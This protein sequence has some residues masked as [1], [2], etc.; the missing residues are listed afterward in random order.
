MGTLK[1][2]PERSARDLKRSAHGLTLVEV[3]LSIAVIAI[4]IGL[5]LPSI[6]RMRLAA[7]ELRCVNNVR[8]VGQFVMQYTA[9]AKDMFPSWYSDR[10]LSPRQWVAYT[11]QVYRGL[12]HRNWL[13]HVGLPANAA[14]WHCPDNQR[15]R[16]GIVASDLDY[17][18]SSSI[19]V[20]PSYFDPTL[21]P[22]QWQSRRGA[23]LQ[24]AS[25]VLWP[26]SKVGVFE[27]EVW[28]GWRGQWSVGVSVEGLLY[29]NSHRPGSVFYFDG[30]AG[31]LSTSGISRVDR[32]PRWGRMPFGTTPWGVAGRDECR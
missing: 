5:A 18:L 7:K 15:I 13:E 10:P 1:S 23:R 2:P 8:Q 25:S 32:Y 29:Y 17:L 30:H 20:E 4:L 16:R 14:V 31:L 21:T 6:A 27:H 3:L 9:D 19:F 22:D 12:S 28:H 11:M 24:S 26:Q